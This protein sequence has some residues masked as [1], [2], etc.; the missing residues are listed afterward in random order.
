MLRRTDLLVRQTIIVRQGNRWLKPKFGLAVGTLHV[1]VYPGLFARE[2]VKPKAAIAEYC[3]AHGGPT[4]GKGSI[5]HITMRLSDAGLRRR[6]TKLIFLNHRLLPWPN[7]DA[8]RDR[9]SR[10]LGPN[11]ALR[12]NAYTINSAMT[13]DPAKRRSNKRKHKIDLAE[14][15]AAFDAPMLTRE[16]A[17]EAY[18][19]QRLIS[20]GW[21]KGRVVVLV[22]TDRDG[23][24]RLIS[25]REAKPHEQEAYFREYPKI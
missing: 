4:A 22:W 5:W 16:D 10:L 21:L 24:P 6:K 18:G 25:C 20:L 3:G 12:L 7:E 8:P 17:S 11:F 14:C 19:E 23:G 2:K 1:N 15:E 13:Y 9:S